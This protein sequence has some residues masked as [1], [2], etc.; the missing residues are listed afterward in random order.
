MAGFLC[1]AMALF[2]WNMDIGLLLDSAGTINPQS[3][4]LPKER[5]AVDAQ[6]P[7]RGFHLPL[8]CLEH[9]EDVV[10]LKGL[11]G[12]GQGLRGGVVSSGLSERRNH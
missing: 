10:P 11:L 3:F 12:A 4:H 1:P 8:V 2:K 9:R 7:G 5:A 6:G